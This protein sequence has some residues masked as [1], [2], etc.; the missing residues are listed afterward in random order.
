[1]HNLDLH[2]CQRLLDPLFNFL[3]LFIILM[4]WFFFLFFVFLISPPQLQSYI[5]DGRNGTL[6]G[7]QPFHHGAF[8]AIQIIGVSKEY[9][10]VQLC[11]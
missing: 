3:I 11:S 1:M 4:C 9:M 5:Q 2:D 8:D 7:T 6:I 10:E